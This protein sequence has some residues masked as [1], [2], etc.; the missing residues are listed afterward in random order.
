[1]KGKRDRRDEID[2]LIASLLKPL[3][4]AS[5]NNFASLPNIRGLEGLY[6]GVLERAMRLSS[7]VNL[8]DGLKGLKVHFHNLDNLSLPL[9]KERVLRIIEEIESIRARGY[10]CM[11]WSLDLPEEEVMARLKRLATPLEGLDFIT[12]GVANRLK[13]KGLEDVEDML[14]FLPIRYEDRRRVKRI[15]DLMPGERVVFSGEILLLGEVYYGRKRMFEM[16]IGDGTGTIRAK[17]F[18]Y[19]PAVMARMFKKGSKV[20]MYGEVRRFGF[21]KEVIHPETEVIDDENEGSEIHFNSIVPIYSHID[22]LHQKRLRKIMREIVDRF[23]QDMVSIVPPYIRER[24]GLIDLGDAIRELHF[25]D[26]MDGIDTRYWK[27]RKTIIFEELFTLQCGLALRR[28][29]LESVSGI[30]FKKGSGLLD[31]FLAS[32]PFKLTG[33]QERVLGEII[34]DMS[35]PHQMNRLIQGDVGSGKTVVAMAS[36]LVAIDSGYQVAMMA[37][38]E[39]LAEQ[40]Y[41]NSKRLLEPTGIRTALLKGGLTRTDRNDVIRGIKDGDIDLIIGTHALIQEGIGYR[42]L[43]LVIIDEQHRFGVIQRAALREK[44][45]SPDVLVMTATPIPRT[46]AMTIFGD[47]DISIIDEMPPNRKPVLTKVYRED[48]MSS[49]YARIREELGAGR[50]AYVVYPL[51]EESEELDLKDATRMAEFL[52]TRIFPEYMVG[53]LH[54]RMRTEEKQE[55]MDRFK[56]GDIHI[57]VTTTVVEVGIDVPNAT[58]MVIEHAER[59][60]LAQL[61]QL[62]GRVGRGGGESICLLVAYRIGSEDAYR[63][64]KVM[65]ETSDGFRIAEED[66]KIRGPGDFLGTRQSGIPDMLHA[67]LIEDNI[68]LKSARD[69]A[70]RL[71]DGIDGQAKERGRALEKIVMDR[72]K[73][74]LE[75]VDV[76]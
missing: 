31:R 59:F 44:G 26:E 1:M 62:R 60:G 33:A 48:E 50:Q 4:F 46:L 58:I 41:L 39:I 7:D 73:G 38:T 37:P 40:H 5:K 8:L 20:F 6:K 30:V 29:G 52:Q 15:A 34:D 32:L 54:G 63:R 72:W 75:L 55:V 18:N 76:A 65:E 43:G 22:G 51:I 67:N 10:M 42:S 45:I 9:K 3:Y 13:K 11:E 68:L 53:L 61:H 28:K 23:S 70:I 69:E 14:N 21:Q 35:S 56:R 12:K 16:V 17:W 27:P 2:Q 19:K 57:L 25:P 47:L 24:Y 36:A 66:L 74:R 49:V 64:L 71:F